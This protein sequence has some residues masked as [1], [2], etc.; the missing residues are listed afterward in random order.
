MKSECCSNNS[1]DSNCNCKCHSGHHHCWCKISI[2]FGLA[3]AIGLF[4]LGILG[5]F[6][7]YGLMMISTIA[8]IYPGYAPTIAGSFIGAF[9]GF[10]D[11]FFFFLIAGFI[12]CGL[13]KCCNKCY[14][15]GSSTC[16]TECATK[17]ECCD[18]EQNKS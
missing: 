6:C 5:A 11:I 13:K 18:T 12:Y 7:N 8:S 2:A 9:W 1:C 16:K 17:G 10:F 15:C 14:C 4:I 3:N